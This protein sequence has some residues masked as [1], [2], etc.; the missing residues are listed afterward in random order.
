MFYFSKNNKNGFTLIELLV[1]VAIIG[2]LSSI[3]IA[4][5]S[6]ARSK[7]Q[8]T[9][10]LA[11]FRSI[12]TQIDITRTSQNKTLMQVVQGT[13]CSDCPFR[14]SNTVNSAARA[15][16]R[17]LLNTEWQM[18]G[19]NSSPLDPWGTPYLFDENEQENGVND[20]RYDLLIS[21]GPNKIDDAQ[22]SDDIMTNVSHFNCP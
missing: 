13:G 7:A 2:A 11:D 14:D 9:R 21:A 17:T 6:G 12:Q 5:L 19:F 8:K 20:C 22:T 16:D 18:V 4:S 3:V 1:V 10:V 15:A